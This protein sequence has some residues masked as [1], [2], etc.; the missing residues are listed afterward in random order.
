MDDIVIEMTEEPELKDAI[1]IEGL[2]GVGNVGKLAV[3]HLM[4]EID[5]TQFGEIYSIYFPPQ[6]LVDEDG[7]TELVNN[8]LYYCKDVGEDSRD[9]IILTGDYQGMTP[10]GQYQLTDKVLGLAEDLNIN[11]VFSLGGYSQGK[12]V[13]EPRVLGAATDHELVHQ[14][15]DIGVTFSEEDPSSGIVGA[16]GLLLGLGKNMYG[17]NGICIMGETSGYFVDPTAARGVLEILAEYLTLD[18]SY[19][20]LDD[21]AEEVEELTNK[22]ADMDM[23]QGMQQESTNEDLN[24]IG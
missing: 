19:E 6:V 18:L 8:R 4:D 23:S 16:S 14:M 2:P 1:L 9:L 3:E 10:Q 22:I 21:K 13:E 12:M 24:Y 11:M 5:A 7:Q 15:E 17:F 20:E